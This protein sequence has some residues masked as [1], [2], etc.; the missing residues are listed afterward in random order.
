MRLL[1][2]VLCLSIG[3]AQKQSETAAPINPIPQDGGP[4]PQRKSSQD[5]VTSKAASEAIP[6]PPKNQPA[7]QE[8]S[9]DSK[10]QTN[11]R[12]YTVQVRS[13]PFPPPDPWFRLS[14]IL[15]GLAVLISLAT[16]GVVYFQTKSTINAER[17]RIDLSFV[18]LGKSVTLNVSNFGKSAARVMT[19]TVTH[20]SYLKDVTELPAEAAQRLVERRTLNQILFTQQMEVPVFQFDISNYLSE[21]ELSGEQTAVFTGQVEYIDIFD[22]P[23][24]TNVVYSYQRATRAFNTGTLTYL[25]KYTEYT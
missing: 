23:H 8:K 24:E 5:R 14:V 4:H 16:L 22:K 25:P 18:T 12:V 11:D 20:A 17:A 2:V 7:G 21:E 6:S 10:E 19:C 15:T 1:L 3:V 13:L 9:G